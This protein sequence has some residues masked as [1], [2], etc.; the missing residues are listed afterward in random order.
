MQ[1]Y[2]HRLADHL[3][4]RLKGQEVLLTNFAAEDSEFVRLNHNQIRQAGTVRQRSLSLD[5]ID[6]R[7]HSTAAVCLSGDWEMDSARLDRLVSELRELL[8]HLPEDPYLLYSTEVHSTEARADSLLRPAHEAIAE[9]MEDARGLDLVG[10]YASGGIHSGFA[11]SLGQRNWFTSYS[12]NFDFSVYHRT[13]KAVKAGYAGF[14]WKRDAL[15][16]KLTDLRQQLEVLKREPRTVPPGH[17]RVY[18]AP[19]ALWDVLSNLAWGGFG[20]KD[21]R[22]KQTTLLRMIEDGARLHPSIHLSE[23]TKDGVAPA[24]QGQGFLRPDRVPLIEN[25][26]FAQCLASPRSAEEYKVPTNGA[27]ADET[28]N[29][30]DLAAGDIPLVD[31]LRRLDTGVYVNNLWY[32]NW[33]DRSNCRMTGMTRF[34]T[35]WVE[36]GVIQSP[37]NVMRFDETA[38]RVLGSNLVGLTAEREFLMDAGSYGARSTQ[39]A[40]LPGLLAGDFHFT[41]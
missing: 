37:L 22:T 11:N 16:Q 12:F 28:P 20:L 33:S 19:A 15:R 39:S 9:V 17:Y 35:F 23:N 27:S 14:Q 1:A 13:D 7:R 10:I 32:L 36:N 8:P 31:M 24:F 41:L 25:G 40:R 4:S 6:G 26:T 5:L 2:F 3:N 34:A 38:Y 29:S 21:H 18:L 30:F